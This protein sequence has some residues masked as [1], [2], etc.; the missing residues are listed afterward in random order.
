MKHKFNAFLIASL[1]CI[2]SSIHFTNWAQN[3]LYLTQIYPKS[4]NQQVGK[5]EKIEFGIQLPFS[6]RKEIDRFIF[7]RDTLGINPFDPDQINVEA[8]FI[9]PSGVHIKRFGFYYQPFKEN[10]LF[11]RW[12][13]DTTSFSWRVRF[14]PN[15]IGDWNVKV[16]VSNKNSIIP[17]EQKLTFSC[18]SS[19]HKGRLTISKTNSATD[20]YLYYS[21]TNEPF[22]SISNNISSGGFFTYTPSQN[23]DHLKGVQQLIDVGGNFTRFDMQPQAALPDWP[24]IKNYTGKL[25][26]MF[27]FDRMVEL[28]EKNGVYFTIFRHHIELLDSE[29]NPGGSD[30]S[31][32]SWYDNPYRTELKLNRKKEYLTNKEAIEWQLKS[33]RYV[34]SRWGY[35]TNFSFYGYSEIDNWYKGIVKEEQ[36]EN[37]NFKEEDAL[38]MFKNWFVQQQDYIHTKLNDKMLYSNSYS[39]IHPSEKNPKFD[40]MFQHS[41]VISIHDY[42]SGK[43]ANFKN[44]YDKLTEFWKIYKKP[45]I[46][47]EMGIADNKLRIYCCTGIEYHNSIWAT[48]MMGGI[49]TGMDWWWNR[50]V[51]D[52]GYHLGL[53]NIQTFF[54]GEKIRELKFQPQKWSDSPSNNTRKIETIALV[55]E[56]QERVLGWLHNSTFYWRNLENESPCIQELITKSRLTYPC[57]VVAGYDVNNEGPGDYTRKSYEDDYTKNGG[58][59]NGG[60][61]AILSKDNLKNNPM[62]EVSKLKKSFRN[63]QQQYKI[64][65][66][67]T[68]GKEL[69]LDSSL[70][71]ILTSNLFGKIKPIV[72]NLDKINPDYGYKITYLGKAKRQL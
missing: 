32:T 50:G 55:S 28:C 40:G 67:A 18:I 72:P 3:T 23:H 8:D 21:E 22:F 34:F 48:A 46:L 19:D 58:A 30:W 37:R 41:D 65:F 53:K 52:F 39:N 59:Q 5:Y 36:A 9:S 33:L 47:E 66:Y 64:E 2:V 71:Q 49:G 56:N 44:R 57:F 35:S 68:N 42:A 61:Q 14:A 13:E 51:Q 63:Q 38:K 11:N 25:D 27:A 4:T 15:E 7:Q 70:T 60:A 43:D 24:S 1:I 45:V 29:T 31:G 20:R 6:L 16:T 17:L 69:F 62:F 10:M 54:K 12:E 26:E